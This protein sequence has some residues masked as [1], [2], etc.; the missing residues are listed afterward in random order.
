MTRKHKHSRRRNI[1]GRPSKYNSAIARKICQSVASGCSREAAAALAGISPST[2]QEWRNQLPEFSEG[3][4]KADAQFERSAVREIRKAG[5]KPRNWAANA[6]MLERRY[7]QK[8]G[9]VDRHLVRAENAPGALMPD[10]YVRAINRALGITG[11]LKPIGVPSL[12]PDGNGQSDADILAAEVL[13]TL[14]D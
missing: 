6:W 7:P 3:L 11:V 10:E 12:L 9:K 4:Q 5:R 2:L 14:P 8:W 13:P 1:I